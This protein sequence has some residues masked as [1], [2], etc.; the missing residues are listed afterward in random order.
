MIC[1]EQIMAKELITITPCDS[2]GRA[3]DLMDKH[4]IGGLP[5]LESERLVGIITSR[6][7]RRTHPNRL[8]A[9]A[10]TR[11]VI[12]VM[13]HFSLWQA[14][15]LMDKHNI[16]RLAVKNDNYL[17]GLLTKARL[18][19][20]W[21]KYVDPLTELN[22]AEFLFDKA[23]D[24]LQKGEKI[25][26]IFF[27]LDDFGSI[28]KLFGHVVGDSILL[29]TA[30]VLKSVT[31]ENTD[32]LCRYGGDEFA[33][34]TNRPWED[35]RGLAQQIVNSIASE[36]WFQGIKVKGSVGVVG[37]QKKL[38]NSDENKPY[39]VSDLFNMASLA[40]SKAKAEGR[41]IEVAGWFEL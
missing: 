37:G 29:Q 2:V 36:E 20:E 18:I 7:V 22:K 4:K 14:K 23:R 30:K 6:D 17:V 26:V 13:P 25:T 34:I 35:A 12:T 41:S 21:G 31:Q 27:D 32:Y 28:D 10:M 19:T 11:D 24:F 5:V 15:D 9:D 8:V 33:I 38:H 3:I 16:E 1:V 39:S 40:S